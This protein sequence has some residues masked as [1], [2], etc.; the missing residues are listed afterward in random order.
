MTD[1]HQAPGQRADLEAPEPPCRLPLGDTSH[2]LEKSS[3]GM[4]QNSPAGKK[5]K[6]NPHTIAD[7]DRQCMDAKLFWMRLDP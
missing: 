3:F 7:L 4:F 5:K 1:A 2:W 6:F